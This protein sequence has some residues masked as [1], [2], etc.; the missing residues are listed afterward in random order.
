MSGSSV[1]LDS[2]RGWWKEDIEFERPGD[3]LGEHDGGGLPP[4][5]PG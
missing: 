1:T 4:R 3:G 2:L 5:H